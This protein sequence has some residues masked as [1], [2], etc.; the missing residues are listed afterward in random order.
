MAP[1][2][3]VSLN[4]WIDGRI[5]MKV[6]VN[7]IPLAANTNLYLLI[8]YHQYDVSRTSEVGLALWLLM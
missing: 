1:C 3:C 6:A 2:L 5:F 4:F 8:T 7:V